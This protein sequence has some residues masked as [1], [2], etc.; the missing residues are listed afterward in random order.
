MSETIPPWGKL[1][2]VIFDINGRVNLPQKAIETY[3]EYPIQTIIPVDQRELTQAVNKGSILVEAY[4]DGQATRHF[5]RLAD[6][7]FAPA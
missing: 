6:H 2:A 3:L 7:F 5:Y 4:P 1:H